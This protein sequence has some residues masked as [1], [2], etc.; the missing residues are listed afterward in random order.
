ML[1]ELQKQQKKQKEKT[2]LL[3]K[4]YNW[5]EGRMPLGLSPS[6]EFIAFML[7]YIVA[8]LYSM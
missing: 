4:I 6:T 2:T 8:V 5:M 7:G 1:Q 3:E